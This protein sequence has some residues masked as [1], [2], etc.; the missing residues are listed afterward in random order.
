[1]AKMRGFVEAFFAFSK[2]R[3][4]VIDLERP[5]RATRKRLERSWAMKAEP[6]IRVIN[7]RRKAHRL[8]GTGATGD[9]EAVN[10]SCRW[11]VRP[12]WRHQYYPSEQARH[13]T[14]IESYVKGPED[15]PLKRSRVDIFSVNR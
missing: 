11:I 4:A 7:L 14:W 8:P 5:P 10:W 1:M 9:G 6:L 15:K 2:Q 12:H 3:I 13:L